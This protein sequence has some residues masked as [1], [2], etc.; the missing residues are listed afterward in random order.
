MDYFININSQFP[1]VNIGGFAIWKIAIDIILFTSE[2]RWL[3]LAYKIMM[4]VMMIMMMMMVVVVVVV[5]VIVVIVVIVMVILCKK[6][7]LLNFKTPGDE[8]SEVVSR[9]LPHRQFK[10]SNLFKVATQWLKIDK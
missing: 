5:V 3:Q 6:A 10:V 4:M 2:K 9:C 1:T 8:T 7:G